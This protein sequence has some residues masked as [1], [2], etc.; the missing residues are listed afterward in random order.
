MKRL[1]LFIFAIV[2]ILTLA[3][4]GSSTYGSTGN[5]GTTPAPAA[6]PTAAATPTPA[7]STTT[8]LHT[9]SATVSGKAVI[10][11]TNVQGMTLYYFLPDTATTAACT[12]GCASTWPP[13]LVKDTS[14]SAGTLPGKLTFPTNANGQQ[15]T[16]N[17]HPLYTYAGDTSPGQTNGEGIGNKWF[18][19]T[20]DLALNK[21]A[22][23]GGYGS[24]RY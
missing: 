7:A 6:T 13:Y 22:T 15:V 21:G 9:A 16:Y 19:A 18:V 17:G 1:H 23:S 12:G 3:A 24:G 20:S 8:I 14:G 4:C 10:L 2:L 11:L 5:A